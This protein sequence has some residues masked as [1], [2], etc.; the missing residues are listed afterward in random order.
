MQVD[1]EI[2]RVIHVSVD[3]SLA[4]PH[5]RIAFGACALLLAIVTYIIVTFIARGRKLAAGIA[6]LIWLAFALG[7]SWAQLR[8]AFYAQTAA[9]GQRVATTFFYPPPGWLAPLVGSTLGGAGA[10]LFLRARKSRLNHD[11]V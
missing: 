2:S 3:G 10:V 5:M 9:Y 6:M 1:L 7:T 4:N 11:V 8:L